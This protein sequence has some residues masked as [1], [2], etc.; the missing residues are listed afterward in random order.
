M[1]EDIILAEKHEEF[2]NAWA[3]IAAFLP[4]RTDNNIK[5]HWNSTLKRKVL[6]GQIRPRPQ[7]SPSPHHLLS[8]HTRV[9]SPILT[10]AEHLRQISSGPPQTSSTGCLIPTR[11]ARPQPQRHQL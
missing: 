10:E 2:G 7:V 5:N 3:K 8:T 4:G 11:D 1:S 6:N 9:I